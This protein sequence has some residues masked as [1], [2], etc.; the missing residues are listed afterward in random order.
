MTTPRL[1]TLSRQ[2]TSD[3]VYEALRHA[4]LLRKFA[5]GQRLNVHEL[6]GELGVSLTPVKDALTRLEAE[7]L[8][9]IRPRSGTFVTAVSPDDVAEAFDIRCALECLA[10]EKALSRAKP[11]DV[12]QLRA[13]TG[14][15]GAVEGEAERLVHASR[16]IEFHKRIVML[17]GNRR[18]VL[19]YE[20]LDAHI[21]IARIH[22]GHA[23]W[24]TRLDSERREHLAIVDAL[25]RRDT[26][27]LVAALRHH[28]LRAAESLV[29]DLRNLNGK[30]AQAGSGPVLIQGDLQPR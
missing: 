25:A 4:I 28:I 23:D 18:L 27:G 29:R 20:S 3:S 19:M 9:Q 13:L 21:Q 15:I 14:Q 8:I 12:E 26:P 16:N 6:A 2:R 30:D 5:P 7:A 11:E 17:S 22:L 1:P 10:A 24:K